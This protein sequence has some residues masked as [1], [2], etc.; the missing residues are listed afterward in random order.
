MRTAPLR[1]NQ[2]AFSGVP[3]RRSSGICMPEIALSNLKRS[4]MTVASVGCL[5]GRTG[6]EPVPFGLKGRCADSYTSDPHLWDLSILALPVVVSDLRLIHPIGPM[7]DSLRNPRAKRCG[8]AVPR[9]G[10]RCVHTTSG[11]LDGP[12][13]S[14]PAPWRRTRTRDAIDVS[15]SCK[16]ATRFETTF[17][18]R[19]FPRQ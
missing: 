16:R 10:F 6:F 15:P 17:L 12:A 5:V 2:R 11:P 14:L 18:P 13:R 19:V 9:R 4:D 7:G 1:R 8:C 3:R